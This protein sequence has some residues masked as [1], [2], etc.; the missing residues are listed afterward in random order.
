MASVDAAAPAPA[1]D[2]AAPAPAAVAPKEVT[3]VPGEK[4]GA[5]GSASVKTPVD[6]EAALL[7]QIEYYFSDSN[8]PRDKFLQAETAKSPEQWCA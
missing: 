6:V 7:R 8:F 4:S 3:F 2:A 5:S 1:A